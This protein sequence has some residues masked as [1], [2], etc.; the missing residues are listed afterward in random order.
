MIRAN[1]VNYKAIEEI[2]KGCEDPQA[3][4]DRFVELSKK[5]DDATKDIMKAAGNYRRIWAMAD[6]KFESDSA[7]TPIVEKWFKAHLDTPI[8]ANLDPS[9]YRYKV[10]E[11]YDVRYGFK[12]PSDFVY[13]YDI[14][15]EIAL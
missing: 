14:Y 4:Y 8:M 10:A 5:R 13:A 11:R 2:F 3:F 1:T 9:G 6:R 7:T 15:M 12:Y